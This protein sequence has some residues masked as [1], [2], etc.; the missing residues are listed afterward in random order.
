MYKI[1]HVQ[2]KHGHS[3]S[4]L[5]THWHNT[6]K[7]FKVNIKCI[8][9]PITCLISC[10][11]VSYVNFEQS[12]NTALVS[13]ML[14]LKMFFFVV[15]D[16]KM[17]FFGF[18]LNRFKE[19]RLNFLFCE[20]KNN[21]FMSWIQ[22]KF[23]D[24]QTQSSLI[25]YWYTLKIKSRTVGKTYKALFCNFWKITNYIHSVLQKAKIESKI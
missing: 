5:K 15:Q 7:L 16:P 19:S 9:T 25:F 22:Q 21:F 18:K 13:L 1:Q 4:I 10:F 14:I 17:F 23:R 24:F 6:A 2:Q 3:Y 20:S 11:D 12:S 8:T